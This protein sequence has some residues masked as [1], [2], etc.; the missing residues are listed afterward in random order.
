MQLKTT[1][2]RH[3]SLGPSVMI[4][5]AI[6][7]LSKHH[8]L[9]VKALNEIFM[10]ELFSPFTWQAEGAI[11][12]SIKCVCWKRVKSHFLIFAKCYFSQKIFLST[13]FLHSFESS[14]QVGYRPLEYPKGW[15]IIKNR[16]VSFQSKFRPEWKRFTWEYENLQLPSKKNFCTISISYHLMPFKQKF[17]DFLKAFSAAVW[18]QLLNRFCGWHPNKNQ[19]ITWQS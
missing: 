16:V 15:T 4:F 19:P 9:Y 8:F 14:A 6:N 1:F 11:L 2:S 7:V 13:V 10:P 5:L 12:V 3:P 17:Q 18:N